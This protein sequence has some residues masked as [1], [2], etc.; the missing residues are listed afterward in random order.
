VA[1]LLLVLNFFFLLILAAPSFPSIYK[2]FN[3][4]KDWQKLIAGPQDRYTWLMMQLD[5]KQSRADQL[6]ANQI[7]AIV[8]LIVGCI[9]LG[10][11]LVFR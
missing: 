10:V 4:A 5:R 7:R 9:P 11:A 6:K 2:R 1:F 8:L 3:S